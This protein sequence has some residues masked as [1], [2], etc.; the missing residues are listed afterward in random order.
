ME[1]INKAQE[2]IDQL[3]NKGK[4]SQD[5]I[6]ELTYD[7]GIIFKVGNSNFEHIELGRETIPILLDFYNKKQD[8]N[9]TYNS[10]IEFYGK[11][12]GKSDRMG[13]TGAL[14]LL[15]REIIPKVISL[16]EK[17]KNPDVREN[18]SY[19]LGFFGGEEGIDVLLK[20]FEREKLEWDNGENPRYEAILSYRF[21]DLSRLGDDIVSKT[22]LDMF[23]S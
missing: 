18:L 5:D 13:A 20:S 1:K 7:L 19:I 9:F 22:I 12:Y 21:R 17:E 4:I 16:F 14:I 6:S 23:N 2:L 8:L 15:G 3:K 11:K 10:L